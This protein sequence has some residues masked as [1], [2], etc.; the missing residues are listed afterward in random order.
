MEKAN[1]FLVVVLAFFALVS[2][3]TL[4]DTCVVQG[5]IFLHNG[6][7]APFGTNVTITNQGTSEQRTVQ[8]GGWGEQHYYLRSFTCTQ[9]SD[10]F[11]VF[12]S[13]LVWNGSNGGLATGLNLYLNITYNNIPPIQ[14]ATL[15]QQTMNEDNTT[16]INNAINLDAYFFDYDMQSLSYSIY[17]QSNNQLVNA[18]I[19]GNYVDISPPAANQSGYSTVCIRAYDSE[20]YSQPGC[21]N[22][23]VTSVPDVPSFSSASDNFSGV[24][25]S[26][27]TTLRITT[28]A[29]DGD[30]EQVILYVCNTSSVT[31]AGCTNGQYC[32]SQSATN[33]S[34]TF[35]TE[36]DENTHRWYAFIYDT[37]GV[38][39]AN[40]FSDTYT[41]DSFAPLAGSVLINNGNAYSNSSTI[42]V[43]WSGYSDSMSGIRY[44]YYNTTNNQYTRNGVQTS[45]TTYSASVAV[46]EGNILIY[47]WAEDF[48]GHIGASAS[49]NIIVDSLAPTITSRSQS[50]AD[51]TEAS[52]TTVYVNY[53][54]TDT[55]LQGNPIYR[56]KVGSENYTTWQNMTSLGGNIYRFSITATW[57]S[58]VNQNLTY[59]VSAID[60]FNRTTNTSYTEVINISNYAPMFVNLTNLSGSQGSNISFTIFGSDSNSNDNLTFTASCCFTIT[61]LDSRSAR[62]W[63]VPPNEYVGQN[64]ITLT[65]SDGIANISQAIIVTVN[66]VND[67]P[68]LSPIGNLYGYVGQPFFYYIYATDPDNENSYLLD[69]NNL[70]FGANGNT[71][72][73]SVSTLY[74]STNRSYYGVLNFTPLSSQIGYF[75]LRFYV[76][77]GDLVDEENS[78][79]YIGYCGDVDAANQPRCDSDYE[80]CSTCP[81][82]C[83]SCGTTSSGLRMVIMVK[84][85]NC[86]NENFTMR[87]YELWTRATCDVMGTIVEGYEVCGNLSGV[88]IKVYRL[89]AGEWEEIEEYETDENGEATF[90]PT[91]EGE[92]KLIGTKR[93]YPTTTRYLEIWSCLSDEEKKAQNATEES[94]PQK[95]PQKEQ[96]KREAEEEPVVLEEENKYGAIM[97]Y[98][99]APAILIIAVVLGY[100]YYDREKDNKVWIL[101]CRVFALQTRKKL[102]SSIKRYWKK[103]KDY[104]GY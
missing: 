27:Q 42:T 23:T 4:A 46:G 1:C 103:I 73:I 61:S 77:D 3:P 8:T 16:G 97:A 57:A 96:P 88:S 81:E 65:V 101:K 94:V 11:T 34:C 80:S 99:V 89:E 19:D 44:Y 33:P 2:L 26:N 58:Y 32:T 64:T 102:Q 66:P 95:L 62:A 98:V 92:Y 74:N 82:D 49:D 51:I 28:T 69:D 93:N 45:N 30:D 36:S 21:F 63:W 48:V 76:T 87:T 84:P 53:T 14:N 41:T 37:A 29:F 78:T 9:G 6:S 13:Y 79:L 59:E 12:S 17:S 104:L 7:A 91:L 68:V 56:Y 85:R 25:L 31:P 83:G 10:Y 22:I 47:V 40:N 43:N 75:F 71:T 35:A 72:W 90:I 50:P 39:A 86:L 55:T 52:S 18:T 54:I 60:Y 20:N 100:Y 5:W 24:Y 70:L 67:A 15:A 38:I